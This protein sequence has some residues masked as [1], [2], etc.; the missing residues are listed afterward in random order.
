MSVAL[1]KIFLCMNILAFYFEVYT[2]FI[3]ACYIH[4]YAF[5]IWQALE[6]LLEP[7]TSIASQFLTFGFWSHSPSRSATGPRGKMLSVNSSKTYVIDTPVSLNIQCEFYETQILDIQSRCVCIVNICLSLEL[8][9]ADNIWASNNLYGRIYRMKIFTLKDTS[10]YNIV[11][12]CYYSDFFS[13]LDLQN[14]WK[15]I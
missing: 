11:Y 3:N 15:V 6:K 9:F 10:I 5:R 8:T 7:A 1:V 4:R 12:T 14:Y 13:M 2:K